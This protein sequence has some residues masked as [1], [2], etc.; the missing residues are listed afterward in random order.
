MKLYFDNMSYLMFLI[1][2]ILYLSMLTNL[3]YWKYIKI[4]I[5][6]FQLIILIRLLLMMK[7]HLVLM[8]G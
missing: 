5:W 4:R 3:N 8:T 2:F 6:Y 1:H 7:P